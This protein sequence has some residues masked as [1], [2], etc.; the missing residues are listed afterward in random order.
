MDFFKNRIFVFTPKGDVLDLPEGAT[1]ID[2]AYYIHTFIGDHAVNAKING[3]IAQLTKTLQNGDMVEILTDN[4]RSA[5][6]REW[7]DK[8]QTNLAKDKIKQ[9]LKAKESNLGKI[10]KIFK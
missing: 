8:V 4:K 2:F 6:S 9:S 10:F 1:P 3:K 7:L 5:P